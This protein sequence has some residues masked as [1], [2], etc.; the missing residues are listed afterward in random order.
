[1]GSKVGVWI[2]LVAV[3]GFSCLGLCSKPLPGPAP[4]AKL[5]VR[6]FDRS[7]IGAN[8]LSRAE[9]DVADAFKA[10][11]IEIQWVGC[12]VPAVHDRSE[13]LCADDSIS[14]VVRLTVLPISALGS[15]QIFH[16]TFGLTVPTGVFVFSDETHDFAE[17]YGFP[18]SHVLAVVIAHELGHVVLGPG[19]VRPGLTAA[20]MSAQLRP[21]DFRWFSSRLRFSRQEA[22]LIKA[23]LSSLKERVPRTYQTHSR[24]AS[25]KVDSPTP[26]P[27][28]C[29]RVIPTALDKSPDRGRQP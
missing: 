12:S 29:D 17:W 9:S 16:P 2:K 24:T 19:H 1:M 7:G 8:T 23:K 20:L 27:D 10:A 3:L 5:I 26:E 4:I 13:P 6:V 11:G 25:S 28:A 22:G 14:S 18:Q 15:P 21:N